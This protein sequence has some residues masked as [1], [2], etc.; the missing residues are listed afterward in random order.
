MPKLNFT[1]ATSAVLL[2]AVI[3]ISV[4]N[5]ILALTL[6][7]FVQPDTQPSSNVSQSEVEPRME[8]IRLKVDVPMGTKITTD[9]LEM[10]TVNPDT[11]PAGIINDVNKIV[12]QRATRD[13]CAGDYL[14]ASDLTD[15]TTA[16]DDFTED[17]GG[18][19]AITVDVNSYAGFLSGEL[20]NGD[21]V[22]MYVNPN[23]GD[24]ATYVPEEMQYLRIVTTTTSTGVDQDR[25]TENVDGSHEMPSSIT[26]LLDEYQALNMVEYIN[27][28]T[29]HFALVYRGDALTSQSYLD[30]QDAIIADILANDRNN[31]H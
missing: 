19:V 14:T 15:N 1:K 21:I 29:I 2:V 31:Q 8:V 10:G 12:G 13:L 4:S 6:F 24:G 26:F 18:K 17:F 28:A 25:V 5:V 3:L 22:K 9:H 27:S 30:K 20:Q 7:G 16:G 11:L 23:D